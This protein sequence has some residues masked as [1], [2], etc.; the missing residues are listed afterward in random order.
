[1]GNA[2]GHSDIMHKGGYVGVLAQPLGVSVLLAPK[3][4]A[5]SDDSTAAAGPLLCKLR[6]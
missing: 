4:G 6:N 2:S 5:K 3:V 1:M